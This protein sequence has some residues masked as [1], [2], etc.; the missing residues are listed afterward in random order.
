[1]KAN[2]ALVETVSTVAKKHGRSP[3]QIAL[4]WV[5]AQGST[6]V[7]IPGTR[8]IERLEENVASSDVKLD[9]ADLATLDAL[10]EPRGARY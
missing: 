7:P 2:L 6:V 9:A 8:K 5:L 3:A 10:P 4:A 1:L